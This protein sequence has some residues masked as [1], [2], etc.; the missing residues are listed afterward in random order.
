MTDPNDPT[1]AVDQVTDPET[2]GAEPPPAQPPADPRV[3]KANREAAA[4]RVKLREVEAELTKLRTESDDRK[5]RDMTD[6]ERARAEAEQ[7]RA[8]AEKA[9]AEASFARAEATIARS[10]VLEKYT[11]IMTSDLIAAQT[12]DPAVN[13]ADWVKQYKTEHAELFGAT[14]P[15]P[16]ATG[17]GGPPPPRGGVLADE[18]RRLEEEHARLSGPLM[19]FRPGTDVQRVSIAAKLKELRGRN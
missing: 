8:E 14:K 11:R 2:T 5:S 19:R 7:A 13:V 17:A 15:A 3:Q 4:S 10:G 16:E 1:Q 9:R 6:T 18:I 12:E